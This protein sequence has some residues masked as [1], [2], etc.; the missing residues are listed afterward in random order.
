MKPILEP[1]PLGS[2]RSIQS[3]CF[4]KPNFETPWHFHPQHELTYIEQSVGTKFIG[5]YVGSYEPGELVLLRSNLPHCWRNSVHETDLA[6]SYV[7]QW[8]V[9]IYPEIHELKAI[10]QLLKTASKGI[11]FE[12]AD[13]SELIPLFKKLPELT[14]PE[15]Y[16]Q[17]LSLLQRLADCHFKSLSEASFIDNLPSEYGS[18]M[19][20]IHDFV[21]ENY[22]RKIYLRE[23]SELINMSE[24]SF[25]RFFTKMMGRSF[26]TFLNEYRVNIAA[27]L[28]LDSDYSIAQISYSCGFESLPFFHKKFHQAYQLTPARY[29]K[30]HLAIR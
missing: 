23:L 8:N 7:V 22:G 15:Q 16:T 13:V 24:Q 30:Q 12:K 17:L 3:F 26:F 28:L 21:A 19:A 20:K 11:I 29:R 2:L 1:I 27:R 25:S 6:I 14:A 5:D 10:H 9:G 4:T 18:R